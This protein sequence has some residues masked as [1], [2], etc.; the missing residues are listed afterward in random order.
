MTLCLE[1]VPIYHIPKFWFERLSLFTLSYDGAGVN[2]KNIVSS[3]LAY[4]KKNVPFTPAPS[5]SAAN[6]GKTSG[7]NVQV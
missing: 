1:G 3:K 7:Q 2:D 6:G 4:L 5:Y